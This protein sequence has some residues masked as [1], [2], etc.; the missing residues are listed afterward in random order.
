MTTTVRVTGVEQ[1][2]H[3][4]RELPR[5]V[6]I[7][8]LR[9]ALNAGGGVIRTRYAQNARKE[10]GLLS[11]SIGIKVRIPDASF[12]QAHHGKP[13]YAIVGVKRNSGRMMRR[14]K[15]GKLKGFGAAQKALRAAKGNPDAVKLVKAQFSDA[16][17]RVPSRYAHLAGKDR[18]GAEVLD[19]SWRQSQSAALAKIT[20]KLQAGVLVEA[21]AL[22][23]K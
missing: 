4:F 23:P 14:N 19:R 21:A 12:N 3:A 1:A 16:Q 20:E 6:G 7:K 13:A 11:K 9:I 17:F 10:S 2:M 15:R 5:R 22:A 18:R 8:H